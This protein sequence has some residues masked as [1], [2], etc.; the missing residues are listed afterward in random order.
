MYTRRSFFRASGSVGRPCH[1]EE[2]RLQMV[3]K[4]A[5]S[6]DTRRRRRLSA[7]SRGKEFALRSGG[8]GSGVEGGIALVPLQKYTLV[9]NPFWAHFDHLVGGTG[10]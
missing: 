8:D 9:L 5:R 3:N 6:G 1:E 7:H 2:R 10:G 4:A